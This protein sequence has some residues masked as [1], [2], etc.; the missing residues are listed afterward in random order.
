MFVACSTLCFGRQTL[1]AALRTISEMGFSKVDVAVREDGPHLKP[2]EVAAD[3]GRAVQQLRAGHGL[4]DRRTAPRTCRTAL[5]R[6]D[7]ESPVQ[8]RLPSCPRADDA[9]GERP[10]AAT[11]TR[12]CSRGSNGLPGSAGW[13]DSK[14][15]P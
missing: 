1:S 4:T 15:S 11:G 8:G 6:D 13:P 7:M 2:S 5:S 10:A 14:A 3:F 12:R 9:A